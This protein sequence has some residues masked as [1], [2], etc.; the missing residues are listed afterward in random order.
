MSTPAILLYHALSLSIPSTDGARGARVLYEQFLPEH[1]LAIGLGA[2]LRES[3][4]GDYTGIRSGA[5]GTVRWFWRRA[6]MTG[7]YAG[8]S[9]YADGDFT[10]DDTDHRW[11]STTI[12][13]GLGAE[14]GYRFQPWRALIVTP[15][16]GLEVH[17]D[18]AVRMP[19]WTRGGL[20]AGLEVGWLF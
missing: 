11:L 7:W 2:E 5:S 8:G 17:H 6:T 13:V 15:C 16:V 9:V 14:F 19:D 10:H 18:F 3:A 4:I 12:S 20:V 1:H